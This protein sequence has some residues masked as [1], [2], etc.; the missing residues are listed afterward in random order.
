VRINTGAVFFK[1][2]EFSFQFLDSVYKEVG[3]NKADR[4]VE[5]CSLRNTLLSRFRGQLGSL[6]FNGSMRSCAF[7]I[8][9]TMKTHNA[10]TKMD[11]LA[12]GERSIWV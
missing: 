9:Q 4:F 12:D 2:S 6:L 5:R 3:L 8:T 11:L 1:A 7:K 10:G